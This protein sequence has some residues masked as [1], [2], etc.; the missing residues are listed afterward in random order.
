MKKILLACS[1]MLMCIGAMGQQ[2]FLRIQV[3]AEGT[4]TPITTAIVNEYCGNK[5]IQFRV[6]TNGIVLVD[7]NNKNCVFAIEAFGYDT[8]YN[9][10]FGSKT[11]LAI[12][13]ERKNTLLQD[14][15]VT[16]QAKHVLAEKSIYKVNVINT[17]TLKQ[18]AANNLGDALASQNNFF[19]Q[20]DNVLGSSINMQGIGGQNIKILINGI[21][22]NGREN[23]NIDASQINIANAERIE[24]V[25]GPMSVLYGTDALGGVINIITKPNAKK[26][27]IGLQAYAE[28]NNTINNNISISTAKKRH[29]ASMHLGR[30]FFAGY[31]YIDT[32]N[33]AQLWKPKEQ[34]TLDAN[35]TYTTSKGKFIYMPTVMLETIMNRG[36][37]SIDPFTAFGVDEYY[38][39]KR[40]A[41]TIIADYELDSMRKLTFSNS[42]SYY[43]RIKN[44]QAKNLLTG[45]EQFT[46]NPGDQDTSTFVDYNSRGFYHS[47]HNANASFMIGYE[48]N[49]QQA[50]SKKLL[51]RGTNTSHVY[52]VADIA[53]FVSIPF[54]LTP[55]IAMQPALRVANNTFYKAP[56][57]PSV[58]LRY[59]MPKQIIL[60]ASYARGFR[61]P[62]LKELYLSFVDVNHNVTGNDTL[63]PEKSNQFQVHVDAPIFTNANCKIKLGNSTYFNSITN[64]IS[65]AAVNVATNAYQYANVDDFK[66]ICNETNVYIQYKKW[67]NTIGA[68]INTIITADSG[69]GFTNAEL[70][71]NTNYAITKH[72]IGINA[73]VRYIGK[74]AILGIS[75]IGRDA[76]Y[77]AYLPS[78]LMAD[79]NITKQLW[80]DKLQ[81]QLGVK[82]IFGITTMAI[83]GNANSNIHGGN[84]RQN[85]SPGRTF[86]V[87]VRCNLDK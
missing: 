34:Y 21:P 83:Q 51:Q 30:N 35:Y 23:G 56:I 50:N 11:T 43:N 87:G 44:R 73:N 49:V 65:L 2:D 37:P 68:S 5:L 61:A 26:T 12:Y 40:I 47:K 69:R 8:K 10:N 76:T 33:R 72:K 22:V 18:I 45:Q 57:T 9:I 58:N 63:Q 42:V 19:K 81:I 71:Y 13:L 60:R 38:K 52:T 80:Q 15:V 7:N 20:Q 36:T 1:L 28:T 75:T 85:F 16:G 41:N 64:Q 84:G 59:A 46:I 74:Q 17:A 32:F 79:A 53:S 39:T 25:K 70:L 55:H 24:I 31:Q 54:Q 67:R 3:F 62:S 4:N 66:N 77:N 27:T 48:V 14:V 82:N 86:F 29:S 78:M 6:D